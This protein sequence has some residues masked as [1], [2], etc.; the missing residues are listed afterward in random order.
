MQEYNNT[1]QPILSHGHWETGEWEGAVLRIDEITD[2]PLDRVKSLVN[3]IIS[4]K[5]IWYLIQNN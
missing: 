1:D 5:L 2:A 3:T 4:E